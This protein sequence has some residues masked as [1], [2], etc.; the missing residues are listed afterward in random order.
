M[1]PERRRK[2]EELAR[3]GATEGERAAARAALKRM[4]AGA[5]D[6]EGGQIDAETMETVWIDVSN[7]EWSVAAMRD[8][9]EV[10]FGSVSGKG[11]IP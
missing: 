10:F 8:V 6:K 2:V 4:D 3:R 11:T 5:P 9:F 7:T 1:N